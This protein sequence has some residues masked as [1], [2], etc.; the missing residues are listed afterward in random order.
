[1]LLAELLEATLANLL[2]DLIL[3]YTFPI[4]YFSL[5]NLVNPMTCHFGH[6]Y[7]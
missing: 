5:N 1:M 4:P 2:D 6:V 3:F 7:M